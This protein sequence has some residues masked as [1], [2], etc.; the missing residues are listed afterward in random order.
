MKTMATL[1]MTTFSTVRTTDA[2]ASCGVGRVV[3]IGDVGD[4]STNLRI[5]ACALDSSSLL[6]ASPTIDSLDKKKSSAAMQIDLSTEGK[7]H[8]M[9][10]PEAD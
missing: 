10:C 9:A 5:A 6:M 2:N 8:E 1:A 3:A 7:M 4:G